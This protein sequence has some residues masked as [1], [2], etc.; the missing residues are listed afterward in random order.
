MK[1][2]SSL[3]STCPAS[4]DD[5]D[6][7]QKSAVDWKAVQVMMLTSPAANRLDTPGHIVEA[8]HS[9]PRR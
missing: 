7:T 5:D 3:A 8:V 2:L 1:S 6:V 9:D 4:P